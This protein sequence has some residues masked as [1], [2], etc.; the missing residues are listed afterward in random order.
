MFDLVLDENHLEDACEHLADFLEEYWRATHPPMQMASTEVGL[1]GGHLIEQPGVP[2]GPNTMDPMQM[3]SSASYNPLGNFA[4][5]QENMTSYGPS[6][7]PMDVHYMNQT[8]QQFSESSPY[9]D[10]YSSE[11]AN[12]T[13]SWQMNN[14]NNNNNSIAV[15]SLYMDARNNNYLTN[16]KK[17]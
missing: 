8:F 7:D 16:D 11:N 1:Y 2:F 12:S 5:Y 9:N 15:P 6:I 14:N 17:S 10:Q 13:S 3:Y 4:N